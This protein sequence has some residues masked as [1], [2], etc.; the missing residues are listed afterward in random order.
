MARDFGV[1]IEFLDLELSELIS[2]R[3]L[4]CQIDKVNGIV[5]SSRGDARMNMYHDIVKKGDA[6]IERMHKLSK[7]AQA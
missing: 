6:L 1:G 2:A 5:E 4:T 7:F 3:Y